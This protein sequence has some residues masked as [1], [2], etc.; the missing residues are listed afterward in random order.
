MVRTHIKIVPDGVNFAVTV[1]T[2]DAGA[3][4]STTVPHLH[5]T[6]SRTN[7]ALRSII[8]RVPPVGTKP[9]PPKLAS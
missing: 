1:E 3:R 2:I 6:R 5:G 9:S 8:G 7:V 4:S